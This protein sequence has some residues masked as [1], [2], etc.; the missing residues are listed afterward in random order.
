MKISLIV[1]IGKNNEIGKDN[2]LLWNISEDLAW[3]KK[4]TINKTVVMGRKTF[5]SIGRPLP[6]RETVVLTRDSQYKYDGIEVIRD[7]NNLYTVNR[8]GT[9][10]MICGGAEIYEQFMEK[11]DRLY[12]THVD[13]EYEADTYFPE[14]PLDRFKKIHSDQRVNHK[15]IPFELCIYENTKYK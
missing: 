2:K 6:K 14:I 11:A 10:L 7:L 13:E 5:E 15:G 1:A 9:E 3:F 12:V 8:L 4:H